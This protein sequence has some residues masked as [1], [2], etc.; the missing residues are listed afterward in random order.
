MRK[1]I[2]LCRIITLLGAAVLLSGLLSGG[3]YLFVMRQVYVNMQSQE[4]LPVARSIAQAFGES[5]LEAGPSQEPQWFRAPLM[6]PGNREFLGAKLHIEVTRDL[7]CHLKTAAICPIPL[8]QILKT[9][10]LSSQMI[11][12]WTNPIPP[13]EPA[14][15][16]PS[17]ASC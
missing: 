7:T 4:L 3:I 1:S 8:P 13:A 9:I 6:E 12:R 5:P 2:F 15:G 10:S 14:W 17:P 11:S 16:F